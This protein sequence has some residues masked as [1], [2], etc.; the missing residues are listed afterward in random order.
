MALDRPG[1]GPAVPHTEGERVSAEGWEGAGGEGSPQIE[2]F[3]CILAV[4]Q[5]SR[6]YLLTARNMSLPSPTVSGE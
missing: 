5:V 3:S 1:K 6:K 2:T 4:V